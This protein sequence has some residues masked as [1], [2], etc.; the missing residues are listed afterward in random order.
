MHNLFMSV[1]I[2]NPK[3]ARDGNSRKVR[4]ETPQDL[5]AGALGALSNAPNEAVRYSLAQCFMILTLP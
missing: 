1:H 3:T 4:P 2:P 5:K